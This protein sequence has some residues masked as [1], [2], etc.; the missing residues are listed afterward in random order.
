VK[1]ADIEQ[2]FESWAP[3][4]TAWERDNVGL[5]VGRRS[6]RVENVL[7]ALDVTLGVVSEA[8][9]KKVDLIV[10]HHPL[11]F[12]PPSSIS[13]SNAIGSILLSL[14]ESRIALY[15]THTNLDSAADGVSFALASALGIQKP[16]FLAPMKDSL[17]KLVIF[18]PDEHVDRVAAVIAEAGAGMIGQ[19]ER[20]SF[21]MHGKGTF[22]GS[23]H[24]QPFSG[25]PVQVEEV[26]EIRL[27]MIVPRARVK[28]VVAAMKTV[29]PYE[30][31]AHDVYTLEN[32]NP[33]FG[34]GAIGDLPR[35]VTVRGFLTK[36]KKA[37]H[38]DSV[39]F[40]GTLTQKVRRIAVCGGGGSELLEHAI[41][42]KADLFVTAD[43]RYHPFHD[44]AGRIVLVDAGHW[45]T[46]Q[47]VLP[48]IASKLRA[49]AASKGENLVVSVTR[50]STNPIHSY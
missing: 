36:L 16:S 10:S 8:V 37:V 4:W 33:N 2:F 21:R 38:A 25:K 44:A 50:R 35:A 7:V 3:L 49:W 47:V 32:L 20:C 30:E 26:E 40:S 45:E 1:L 9:Q 13:D 39:R 22:R 27:E 31:I 19:Y 34:M 15:S 48:V 46:E 24:T 6:R 11:L 12:R 42:A 43:V 18:V 23:E 17:V 5:Q 29:H 14:A 41:A 28:D